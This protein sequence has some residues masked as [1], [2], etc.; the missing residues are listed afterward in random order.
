M[1]LHAVTQ[2]ATVVGNGLI[3][4][5]HTPLTDNL[6]RALEIRSPRHCGISMAGSAMCQVPFIHLYLGM[7]LSSSNYT[8]LSYSLLVQCPLMQLEQ[9]RSPI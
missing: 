7:A 9:Q 4:D 5:G 2:A 8:L 6:W 1:A 3:S